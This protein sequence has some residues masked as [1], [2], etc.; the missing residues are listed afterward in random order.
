MLVSYL[1]FGNILDFIIHFP[2]SINIAYY[3]PFFLSLMTG[4]P[5]S[6][7]VPVLTCG[8]TLLPEVIES[9]QDICLGTDWPWF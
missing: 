4:D 7:S 1:M 3:T 2:G 6:V 9:W 8:S 5:N